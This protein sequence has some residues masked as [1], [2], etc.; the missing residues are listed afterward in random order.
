MKPR[1]INKRGRIPHQDGGS[2]RHYIYSS[3]I[4]SQE[5]SAKYGVRGCKDDMFTMQFSICFSG[6]LYVR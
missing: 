1:A 5:Y 2:A 3:G 4:A 6:L